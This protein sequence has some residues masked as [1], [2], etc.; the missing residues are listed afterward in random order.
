MVG[1]QLFVSAVPARDGLFLL[2]QRTGKSAP[3]KRTLKHVIQ[4]Y[5]NSSRIEPPIMNVKCLHFCAESKKSN[6]WPT[7]KYYISATIVNQHGGLDW[8]MGQAF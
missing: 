4:N 2:V 6:I 7:G 8:R 1:S 3:W 5:A